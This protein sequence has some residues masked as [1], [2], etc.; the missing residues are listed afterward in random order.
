M[1][2]KRFFRIVVV[3]RFFTFVALKLLVLFCLKYVSVA[4]LSD[5]WHGWVG[6]Y[7]FLWF[8]LAFEG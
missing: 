8:I 3:F 6:F 5:V 2:K 7:V 4:I 1:K